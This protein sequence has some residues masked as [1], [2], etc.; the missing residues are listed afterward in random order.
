MASNTCHY[1]LSLLT[2]TITLLSL[3]FLRGCDC[4]SLEEDK[5]N[6]NLNV[7]VL[8]DRLNF[9]LQKIYN[10]NIIESST[11][12]PKVYRRVILSQSVRNN[13]SP[14]QDGDPNV[15]HIT[16]LFGNRYSSSR[17]PENDFERVMNGPRFENRLGLEE[18]T[19]PSFGIFLDRHS[20]M[21]KNNNYL[22]MPPL[23]WDRGSEQKFYAQAV[24]IQQHQNQKIP[25]HFPPGW[26]D[27]EVEPEFHSAPSKYF[28]GTL[29]NKCLFKTTCIAIDYRMCV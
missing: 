7:T 18:S 6:V 19:T 21:A 9:L 16:S 20:Y 27:V 2:V 3:L 28:E 8:T 15:R 5:N 22:G 1:S 25:L 4:S 24:P 26:T 12:P 17:T 14:P 13:D 23:L 11:E 10:Q 29:Y